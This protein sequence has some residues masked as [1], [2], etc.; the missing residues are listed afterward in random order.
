VPIDT[1]CPLLAKASKPKISRHAHFV[2][3]LNIKH[4]K[5]ELAGESDE[6]KR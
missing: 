2:A 3:Q 6:S 4:Y 5:Q 1:E